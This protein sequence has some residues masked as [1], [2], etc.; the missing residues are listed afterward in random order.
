MNDLISIVL[1]VYNGARFL[2]E[3][4]DSVLAQTHRNWELLIL[5]DCSTDETPEIA[6]EYAEKDPRIHYHRNEVN[7]KL[8]G[9]LNAGF[10]M[11]RGSYLTWTSDDNRFRPMALEKMLAALKQHNAHLAYAS[12]QVIDEDG[13]DTFVMNVDPRGAEHILGSN[14]V[15]ACFLYTREV[16][17]KV[18]E[19]DT[20]LFL[21]EDF[22]YWQ[23]V[24]MKFPGIAIQE[25]LY[26]YRQ[27]GG[28]L[29][30]T[31]NQKRYGEV[32]EKMLVTNRPG[33]GR[34]SMEAAYYY[35]SALKKSR[36]CQGVSNP[37]LL[38]Y[39]ALHA[40]HKVKHGIKR[41]RER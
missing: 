21:V 22:D 8:P 5:D 41:I 2:R 7:L 20:T 4:I 17:E 9:N 36:E 12:Y 30:S 31:K 10:R 11:A 33:F 29:T 14:V 23:R 28:S 39:R 38:R 1:P 34:I 3:S 16:Y 24:F 40:V 35:Y 19:Y 13:N 25:V 18:G 26:D 37:D 32:L 15:G 27:H 6:K